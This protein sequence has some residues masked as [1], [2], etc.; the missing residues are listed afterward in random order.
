MS[1]HET[2]LAMVVRS[3]GQPEVKKKK[4]KSIQTTKSLSC[5]INSRGLSAAFWRENTM[6]PWRQGH[7]RTHF[8][9]SEVRFWPF[10]IFHPLSSK[11]A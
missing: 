10:H 4:K 5:R 9:T 2:I 3:P 11:I 1:I 7:R 6:T 8:R